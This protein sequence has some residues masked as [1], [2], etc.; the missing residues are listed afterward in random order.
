MPTAPVPK[1]IP[2]IH[3]VDDDAS[4]RT[5]VERLLKAAGYSVRTYAS[6]AEFL[7]CTVWAYPG[8][9][10]LDM[11]MPD[12]TGLDVQ[13]ALARRGDN[14]PIIFISGDA[15]IP[16]TVQAL[17]SGAVDFLT[18][19]I[20]KD[21]LLSTIALVLARDAEA[22][23][24]CERLRKTVLSFQNLTSRQQAVF[25]GV[26]AGKLNKQI[27]ADLGITERTIKA[28]RSEVMKKMQVDSV[29]GLVHL[30]I[31]LQGSSGPESNLP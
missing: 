25:Q 10:L 7:E 26:I 9:I 17:K 2:T 27:A 6:G 8:C 16:S 30:A 15:T 22:R 4:Y 23:R 21:V 24:E 31:Q 29:A 5:A 3:I 1:I 12:L 28:H 18:K 14:L 20:Q 11:N 19:P 13:S